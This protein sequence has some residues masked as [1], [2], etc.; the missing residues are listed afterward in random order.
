[1]HHIFL[2]QHHRLGDEEA[3]Y[4]HLQTTFMLGGKYRC[5][6]TFLDEQ[7]LQPI[8]QQLLAKEMTE[9]WESPAKEA[10]LHVQTLMHHPVGYR[11]K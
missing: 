1:M 5:T 3:V 10:V 6:R 11:R 8:I 9:T 7:K 4:N 2:E